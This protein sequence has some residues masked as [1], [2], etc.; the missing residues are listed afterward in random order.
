MAPVT[1][2]FAAI[3]LYG[4]DVRVWHDQALG[5]VSVVEFGANLQVTGRLAAGDED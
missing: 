4:G 5:M 1:K 3:N 2:E